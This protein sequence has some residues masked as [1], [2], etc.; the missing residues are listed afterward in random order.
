MSDLKCRNCRVG[1]RGRKIEH[2]LG[3]GK[4]LE[5][6]SEAIT[7]SISRSGRVKSLSKYCAIF[8]NDNQVLKPRNMFQLNK[9]MTLNAFAAITTY[10][11][12]LMQFKTSEEAAINNSYRNGN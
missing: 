1:A 12:V 9:E 3:K 7:L 8:V 11:I 5:A 4:L 6:K 10:I 2:A